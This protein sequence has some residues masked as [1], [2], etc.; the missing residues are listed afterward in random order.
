MPRLL[1]FLCGSALSLSLV[2]GAEDAAIIGMVGDELQ[3]N[4]TA[5]RMNDLAVHGNLVCSRPTEDVDV[6]GLQTRLDAA[7]VRLRIVLGWC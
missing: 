6:C 5:V 1:A 2:A 7:E 4:A 3:I